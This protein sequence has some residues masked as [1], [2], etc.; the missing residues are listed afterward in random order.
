M[1][2]MATELTAMTQT[3]KKK[4]DGRRGFSQS[5]KKINGTSRSRQ[6]SSI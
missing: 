4:I 2:V 5:K 1:L 6:A 3:L